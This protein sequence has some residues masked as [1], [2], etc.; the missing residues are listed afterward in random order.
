MAIALSSI[1]IKVS[2]AFEA[3]AGT[4][5]TTGYVHLEGVKELPELNPAPDTLET[6][7]FDNL[8]YKTY[9]NGLKD[10]GGALSFT[11]NFTQALFDEWNGT[12]GV[13]EQYEENIATGKAMWLCIDIP[14]IDQ[15]CFFTC[16][17]SPIGVP[18][19]A[20]N[21]VLETSLSITPTGEPTWDTKPTYSDASGG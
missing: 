8:E 20:T 3:V 11:A 9:I 10:L 15:A 19:V 17:P 7:T 6:T 13:M 14:G 4:R 1:G 2:Y 16:E 5:P 21:E 18:G 12:D